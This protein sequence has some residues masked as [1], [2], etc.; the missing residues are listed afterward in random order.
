[1]SANPY[2]S[3][4]TVQNPLP[5]KS[6]LPSIVLQALVVVGILAGLVV[7]LLPATRTGGRE[8]ARRMQCSN[9]LKQIG[10]ALQNYH[11]DYQSLPPPYITDAD[12]KPMHSWRILILPYLGEKALYDRY[13][14]N[15]PWNGPSNSKLHK[16][17]LR[18][19]CCPSRPGKQSHTETSYVA[20]TGPETAWPGDK[21]VGLASLTDGTSN[22]ILV[23]EV[24]DS[25]IH[26]MQPRDLPMAQIPMSVKPKN[27]QG[28]S[29]DHPNVALVVFADGHTTALTKNTP[30]E[31]LRRL[32]TI[33]D[34]EPIGDY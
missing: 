18:V 15:E 30:A 29:S 26:W 32:L 14:F 11:D 12:G 3:P 22:T 1:M 10:L 16:E 9:H 13:D 33:A 7:L 34:G 20:V 23:V 21:P 5:R 19:F 24:A 27:G 25:G 6:N 28:I 8:A 31:I 4:E 2:E 17:T